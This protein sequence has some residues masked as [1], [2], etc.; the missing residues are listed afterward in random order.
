MIQLIS[1]NKQYGQDIA[2]LS[3][4]SLEIQDGE[5]VFLVG[6]SGSGKTTL[7]KMLIREEL[8]TEG[9]IFFHDDDI[10]RYNRRQVYALRRKIGVI[11]QDYK[12]IPELNAYENVA[13]AMEAAGRSDRD[14]KEN[15]PYLLDI[16]GLSKRMHFF[17]RMLSG[18]EKQRVAIARAMANNPKLL[19]A[20]EPTGNL[21]PDSAWDIVQ[22]LSKINNWGTTVIMST[23]GSDIV[24]SLHKRVLRMED[25]KLVRDDY[26]GSYDEV[27]EFS[28][29]VLSE[30]KNQAGKAALVQEQPK[31]EEAG[32]TE[33]TEQKQPVPAAPDHKDEEQAVQTQ[34]PAA[35]AETKPVTKASL[36]E[37]RKKGR[38][39]KAGSDLPVK[40]D[41]KSTKQTKK[42]KI[43]FST[44]KR[45]QRIR[46]NR[47]ARWKK[48]F[49]NPLKK[50]LTDRTA[51]HRIRLKKQNLHLKN[52][53]WPW[54]QCLNARLRKPQNRFAEVA[55]WHGRL[56]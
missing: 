44:K 31:P 1:V 18:G 34:E 14:I 26:R 30:S 13:F 7:I 20:D 42:R 49:S 52:Q 56:F 32:T 23:H 16:V 45:R 15:V 53:T 3:D 40:S 5:F 54:E 37:E 47:T 43:S 50:K 12:L 21:D 28:L 33:Q 19:I 8:P 10:T 29:K 39:A 17:P 2:A 24:N 51:N 46:K 41:K 48:R 22:I 4:I 55:G 11:F 35:D 6:P 9:K 36:K 38:T 27:D 25:G